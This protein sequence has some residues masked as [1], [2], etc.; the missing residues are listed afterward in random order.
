MKTAGYFPQRLNFHPTAAISQCCER[1]I[2]M[3]DFNI[4]LEN[5]AGLP[6]QTKL[7][8]ATRGRGTIDKNGGAT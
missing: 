6:A 5:R 3:T 8:L 2:D 1:E 4:R 7:P